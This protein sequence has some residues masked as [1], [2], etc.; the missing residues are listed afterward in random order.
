M[1]SET[2]YELYSSRVGANDWFRNSS[3][4]YDTL[5]TARK[6]AQSGGWARGFDFK[7][8][9]VTRIEEDAEFISELSIYRAPGSAFCDQDWRQF[10]QLLRE[11]TLDA[12]DG[13][14]IDSDAAYEY[15]LENPES[16]GREDWP[17]NMP[18][19]PPRA[20]VDGYHSDR[21]HTN[22]TEVA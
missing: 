11:S 4:Q 9:R 17:K 15:L 2:W 5:E 22:R 21:T 19:R 10:G 12:F 20:L 14:L 6:A 3:A 8:I 18:T 16:F 1:N 7:I 13:E